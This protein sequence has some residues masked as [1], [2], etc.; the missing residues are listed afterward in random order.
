MNCNN[1]Y[2]IGAVPLRGAYFGDGLGQILLDNVVC[3]GE[4]SSLLDCVHELVGVHNCD[5]SE[6]AGVRCEGTPNVH[7]NYLLRVWYNL[8]PVP[9]SCLH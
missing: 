8:Y 7:S 5:H 4:E 9:F 3:Q 1:Y 6:D 2:I